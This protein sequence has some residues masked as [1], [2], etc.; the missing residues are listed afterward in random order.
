M[1]R[2]CRYLLAVDSEGMTANQR[3]RV[4]L[5]LNNKPWDV[6]HWFEDMWLIAGVPDDVTKD[7]LGKEIRSVIPG[8][9]YILARM[10]E[11]NCLFGVIPAESHPWFEEKWK[12][13]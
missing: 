7:E 10:P 2:K 3:D 13:Q 1:A 11:G 4:T 9:K 12:W 6:W 8:Q 5:Y